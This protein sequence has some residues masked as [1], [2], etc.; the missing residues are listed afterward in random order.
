MSFNYSCAICV[1]F[2]RVSLSTSC[3]DRDWFWVHERGK[4]V[5]LHFCFLAN[6]KGTQKVWWSVDDVHNFSSCKSS[7]VWFQFQSYPDSS[8]FNLNY[9]ALFTIDQQTYS[10]V[11]ERVKSLSSRHWFQSKQG[12]VHHHR[13]WWL[14][15]HAMISFCTVY[16]ER[17]A[18]NICWYYSYLF[19]KIQMRWW[20][21]TIKRSASLT[22]LSFLIKHEVLAVFEE[23]E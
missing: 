16:K 18:L 22:H 4:L 6:R 19:S 20:C 21:K 2:W 1:L 8:S 13:I 11:R 23:Q 17:I 10:G 5:E 14:T 9:N 12:V 15:H 3:S 7:V